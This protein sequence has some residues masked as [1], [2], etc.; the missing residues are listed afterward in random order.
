MRGFC[1]VMLSWML[2]VSVKASERAIPHPEWDPSALVFDDGVLR[3]TFPVSLKHLVIESLFAAGQSDDSR[4]LGLSTGPWDDATLLSGH[5]FDTIGAGFLASSRYQNFDSPLGPCPARIA[6]IPLLGR[7][8][9]VAV[10]Y[11]RRDRIDLSWALTG[12]ADRSGEELACLLKSA[13]RVGRE[14]ATR[15]A[16][17]EAR[18][19]VF[20]GFAVMLPWRI[21]IFTDDFAVSERADGS[22]SR[23]SVQREPS[24]TLEEWLDQN[25]VPPPPAGSALEARDCLVAGLTARESGYVFTSTQAGNPVFTCIRRLTSLVQDRPLE[26]RYLFQSENA[27]APAKAESTWR[28]LLASISFHPEHKPRP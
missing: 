18:E 14:D 17:A 24:G 2:L 4:A 19:V 9:F 16:T 10:P 3:V 5:L 1:K 7:K 15:P 26:V 13:R 23:F 8:C 27:S 20:A 22:A 6:S 12:S 21:S 28:N 11:A 25:G